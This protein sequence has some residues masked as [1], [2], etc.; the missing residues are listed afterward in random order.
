[1]HR[2][3]IVVG[4]VAMALAGCAPYPLHAR[5]SDSEIRATLDEN[6][7]AGMTTSQVQTTLEALRIPSGR[8][9]RYEPTPDRPEVLLARIFPAGGGWVTAQDQIIDF[10]D[11]SFVFEPPDSLSR[12][13]I[14]RDGVRY[15]GG[16]VAF[17]PSRT[18]M[19]RP[20]RFP[21]AVAPPVDPL[22]GAK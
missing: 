4:A 12:W 1:M 15:V 17:G 7:H 3:S 10:V 20:G 14:F 2:A 19:S 6:F 5:M 8:Q 18:P 9:L 22:E 16:R 21:L 13:P 11:V